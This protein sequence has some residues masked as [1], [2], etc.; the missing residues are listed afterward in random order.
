MTLLLASLLLLALH[1]LLTTLPNV[2]RFSVAACIPVVALTLLF[3]AFLLYLGLRKKNQ[4]L[5]KWKHLQH[6]LPLKKWKLSRDYKHLLIP[7]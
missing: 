1:I 7:A 3:L 4:R 5:R 2:A 6:C